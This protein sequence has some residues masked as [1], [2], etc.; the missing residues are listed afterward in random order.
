M[1][2]L[3]LKGKTDAIKTNRTARGHEYAEFEIRWGSA[4]DSKLAASVSVHWPKGYDQPVV[5]V[6]TGSEVIEY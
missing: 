2:R 6:H 4:G 1:S 5:Y 3:Y